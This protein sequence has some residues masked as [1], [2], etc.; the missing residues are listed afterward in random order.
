MNLIDR[1]VGRQI[2]V[3]A[4]LGIAVLS[5]VLVLYNVFQKLFDL[6]VNHDIPLEYIISFIAYLL[7]FSLT[8]TIPWGF[9]TAVL[10]VF[11]KMSAENELIALRSHGV[12]MPRTCRPVF[13][14]AAAC[15]AA[16]LWINISVAPQAQEQMK[17]ALFK[18]AT[19][20]PIAMFGSD[21]VI[22]EF[23]GKR[24]YVGKKNGNDLENLL[25]YELNE[26]EDPVRVVFARHGR[27][28][29]DLQNKQVLL[30]LID[31]RFEQ[32]DERDPGEL[33]KI[34]PGI[35]MSEGVLPISLQE[36]YEK[37]RRRR[38]LSQ[39]TL[40]EL[41]KNHDRDRAKQ[42]ATRT[43][44]NKRFAAGLASLAF[45]LIGVPLAVT[46]HRKETSIGF[47]FSLSIAFTYFFFIIIADNLRN[48]PKL[49]PEYLIWFP[50]VLFMTLGGW[51]FVRLSRR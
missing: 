4:G 11:G 41:L 30:R 19:S 22:D 16:C 20:N 45:A 46:A 47:L 24:I 8:F 28:D 13:A 6:L 21:E 50:N 40:Q 31:A 5:L 42:S 25:M 7:P 48:D 14:L 2:V 43:E 26:E 15:C 9:L 36:L 32:R 51:L 18:I 35:T 29:T 12:S 1:Y 27:L 38:G 33:G 44:V 34:R 49:F 37:N 17:N 3:T 39:M 10:L 23:P